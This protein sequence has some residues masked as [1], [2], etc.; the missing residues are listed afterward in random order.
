MKWI[1]QSITVGL[2]LALFAPMAGAQ[3]RHYMMEYKGHTYVGPFYEKSDDG[4]RTFR[5]CKGVEVDLTDYPDVTVN[6]TDQGCYH[7]DEAG[8]DAKIAEEKA[9]RAEIKKMLAEYRRDHANDD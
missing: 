4:T 7:L 9:E 6:P 3:H 5:T 1:M 8:D 2:L